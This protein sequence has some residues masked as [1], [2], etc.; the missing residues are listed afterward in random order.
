MPS[1]SCDIIAYYKRGQ[2]GFFLNCTFWMDHVT[3][4]FGFPFNR[5]QQEHK[6]QNFGYSETFLYFDKAFFETLRQ[7]SL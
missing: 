7:E 5:Q 1:T 2:R 3:P 6:A 4:G